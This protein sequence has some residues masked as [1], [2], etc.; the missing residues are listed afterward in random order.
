MSAEEQQLELD[1]QRVG[2]CLVR[3]VELGQVD[4]ARQMAQIQARLVC[5]RSPS[6][7]ERMERER[8]LV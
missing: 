4:C 7:V 5:S 1:I 3:L 8:G 6:T 2:R